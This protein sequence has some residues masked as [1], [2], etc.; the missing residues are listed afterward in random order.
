MLSNLK[1]ECGRHL[2]LVF[3]TICVY[4]SVCLCPQTQNIITR[5]LRFVA[6]AYSYS[7]SLLSSIQIHADYCEYYGYTSHAIKQ[8]SFFANTLDTPPQWGAGDAEIKVLSGEN[9]ELKR[10]PSK[11]WSRSVYSHT[12]HAYCQRFLP[13]LLYTLPVHSPAFFAKPLP[14]FPVMTVANTWFLCR[15]AE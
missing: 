6:T 4:V 10:S 12:F 11:A 2:F 15:L 9:S 3:D 13:C 5:G 1:E 14:S 8:R 7:L